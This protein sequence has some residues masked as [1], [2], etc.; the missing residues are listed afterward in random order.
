MET[1]MF[2]QVLAIFQNEMILSRL[3]IFA[4]NGHELDRNHSGRYSFLISG[5]LALN[6]RKPPA[7]FFPQFVL[8]F[9]GFRDYVAWDAGRRFSCKMGD[10]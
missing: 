2:C 10:K 3:A 7:Y 4:C 6:H 8:F 5:W 9:F 1:K